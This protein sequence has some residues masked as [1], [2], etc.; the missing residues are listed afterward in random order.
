MEMQREGRPD[1][2]ISCETCGREATVIR[3]TSEFSATS[4]SGFQ[5]TEEV[6]FCETHKH[7]EG[8]V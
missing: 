7:G 5:V 2:K 1:M 8:T 6:A 4:A 3:V